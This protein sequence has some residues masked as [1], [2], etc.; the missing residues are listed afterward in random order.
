MKT[1]F[2]R[3]IA[4]I[5]IALLC[6]SLCIA[7]GQDTT[8]TVDPPAND[9]GD[10]PG[11][12][13]NQEPDNPPEEDVPMLNMIKDG[14]TSYVVVRPDQCDSALK[15]SAS[16]LQRALKTISGAASISIKTDYED[17]APYEILVGA[18]NRPESAEVATRLGEDDYRIEI[19]GEKLVIAGRDD[20]AAAYGVRYLLQ[21][22]LG[23]RSANNFTPSATVSL[24]CDLSVTGKVSNTAPDPRNPD[25]ILIFTANV[26]DF[27]AAGDGATDDTKAFQAAIDHVYKQGGGTVFVPAGE[28]VIK[29]SLTV[30]RSVYLAGEWTNPDQNPDKI[31]NGT[32]LLA[33]GNKG[34]A[35]GSAMITIGASAGV[36]GL[37]IYY[38]EQDISKPVAY[39]AAILIK[40]NL[41]G[42]GTQHASSVQCV[43]IVNAYR[44]IAADKGNQLPRIDDVYMSVLDY[45]FKINKCYDCARITSMHIGPD[46]WAAFTG[47][48]MA[49]IAKQ[50][51]QAATGII[52]MRTDGQ[53]M[54]D[55]SVDSCYIGL[56]L[57]R[58]PEDN[59]E[60]AGYSN[61]AKVNITECAIGIA[62]HYNS[63]SIS[64]ANISSTVKNSVGIISSD[65]TAVESTLRL[66]DCIITTDMS[67][68]L[69]LYGNGTLAIQNS[70]LQNNSDEY[71]AVDAR[72]GVLLLTNNDLSGCTRAYNVTSETKA[73]AV[74]NNK[75]TGECINELDGK[76]SVVQTSSV[77]TLPATPDF[78][79]DIPTP[80]VVAATN[81]IFNVRDYGAIGDGKADD[82]LAFE[83]AITAASK[84][85]GIVY[86]PA[87]YYNI[88]DVL[89][90][91]NGVELR[92][93]HQSMHVTTGEGSVIYI[94]AGQG[95]AN[96]EAFITMMEGSGLRGLTFWYPEQAWNNIKAYP[97]TVSVM[98]ENCVLRD[99]C[100][101]NTYQA[102]D[103]ANAD[104]GGHYVDNITGCV[105][106]RGIVLDGSSSA[107][108]IM[109]THFNITFYASV[110]GTKLNDASGSFGSGEMSG[111]LFNHMNAHL[112]AYEFGETV[113]E[114]LLF[115]F[116]YRARYGMDFTGGFDGKVIGS[117]VDGSLC[118]I[119]IKGSYENE[120]L[121]LNFMDDIVPGSTPE[122]NLAIYVDVDDDSTVRFVAGSASSY[123]YVP[124]GLIVLE[125]GHLILD[126][127]DARVTPTTGTGA[128]SIRGGHAEASGVVFQHVGPLDANN[129]FSQQVNTSSTVDVKVFAGAQLDLYSAIGLRFFREN[130]QGSTGEFAYAIAN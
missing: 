51:Q 7:C 3:A 106:S 73:A 77:A 45:G 24:R 100:F 69:M 129:Q 38:P 12:Q 58:N 21:N 18:T 128:L 22:L 127:F 9:P 10:Q 88:T 102:I 89:L 37:T 44:G 109:N 39:P 26:L 79:L 30:K 87:G 5:M 117:G 95:D 43:T 59:G 90:I 4:F 122:G 75:F 84:K 17:A 91:P 41:A 111:A 47:E 119:R 63:A 62:H 50:M 14:V 121:L 126:G 124:T 92:G 65:T 56:S 52:L 31:K 42:D 99:L 29:G 46:Y 78:T 120:L 1:H 108:I 64:L 28:Y 27:G 66:Y 94:T 97:F 57:E 2:L 8:D 34:K 103:M 36:L 67:C 74:N 110:W 98:G 101:G 16:L 35:D 13:P 54:Y 107:G 85:G 49:T 33:T 25:D 20:N 19:V 6:M 71:F 76:H 32:V 48:D 104:C 115:I 83:K 68:A 113:E 55:I 72:G 93:V 60:T 61:I 114:Q 86:V 105:L 40:D 125:N 80:P 70:T 53:M 81:D 15:T 82:T 23:Y 116:N 123:N 11:D 118:G 130:I 96:D 112:T